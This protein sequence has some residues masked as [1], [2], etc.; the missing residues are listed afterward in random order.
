MRLLL[1]GSTGQVGREVVRRASG[2]T[3]ILVPDRA[4]ADL[5]RPESCARVVATAGADAVV[6][7]AA[8]TAVDRAEA[9]EEAATLVNGAAPGAMATACAARGLPLLHLSTDYVFDGSGDRPFAPD[10]E[11]GPLNAY[12]RSKLAGELAVRRSGARHL[13]LRTSWVFSAHGGNF[14]KTMLALGAAR[15]AIDVVADQAGGPT[16]AAAIADA[17]LG[18]ARA[19]AAG[20]EGGTHHFAGQPDTSWAEFARAI[21]RAAGLSCHVRDIPTSGYPT[22]ARRPLNS[23]LYCAGF[24]AAFG[25]GRPDWRAGLQDVLAELEA[26]A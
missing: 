8:W 26:L 16:P 22:P 3:T 7:C 17:L 25:I 19:M 4:E 21:M 13:I 10:D 24:E 15:R 18:S 5:A 2:E 12:G 14:V 1:F 20:A 11:P 23:R 9:Q 6:N